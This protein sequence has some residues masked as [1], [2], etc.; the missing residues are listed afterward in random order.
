MAKGNF[1]LGTVTKKLGEIV[2][3]RQKGEQIM[4]TRIRKI[5]N[6]Q[7]R[8]QALQRSRLAALL[9][10][11]RILNGVLYGR[12]KIGWSQYNSFVSRNLKAARP[13]M[14]S[15][16]TAYIYE[17]DYP[18]LTPPTPKVGLGNGLSVMMPLKV[19][20][21]NLAAPVFGICPQQV[22]RP[23][24]SVL[25]SVKAEG[26]NVNLLFP[27]SSDME[28][29]CF[30]I[31]S[32]GVSARTLA[33]LGSI[34]LDPYSSQSMLNGITLD[35]KQTEWLI[36]L[37]A[38]GNRHVHT[39]FLTVMDNAGDGVA[40][41]AFYNEVGDAVQ[42]DTLV[43]ILEVPT[44]YAVIINGTMTNSRGETFTIHANATDE[45]GYTPNDEAFVVRLNSM[46]Y[47]KNSALDG[48]VI[49]SRNQ[50]GKLRLSN[51]QLL[52]NTDSSAIDYQTLFT[53]ES[54]DEAAR[55]YQKSG[56][57]SDELNLDLND[58]E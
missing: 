2:F 6:P 13:T 45:G 43:E 51:S 40:R 54:I 19:T 31:K 14:V 17:A 11:F 25:S 10:I 28:G 18:F 12:L 53:A 24:G 8:A 52:Q 36:N 57:Q 22:T 7:T 41:T 50:N 55:D 33:F 48:T 56:S 30:V 34:G 20:A 5:K 42:G 44:G 58:N 46:P 15:S 21:G 39:G 35:A 47:L 27:T 37:L 3:S 16:E 4:R 23:F 26:Y 32:G 29:V 38:T 1:L 49:L 9:P